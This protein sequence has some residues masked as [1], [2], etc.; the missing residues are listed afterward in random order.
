MHAPGGASATCVSKDISSGIVKSPSRF[1]FRE[2]WT[3][4]PRPLYCQ[5][6][7]EGGHMKNVLMVFTEY[8]FQWPFFGLII[9]S[10]C[11]A[12]GKPMTFWQFVFTWIG[13]A[14]ITAPII[15][16]IIQQMG[17]GG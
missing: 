10:I 4:R 9:L 3:L 1:I 17:R 13:L 16:Y 6:W 5:R 11:R 12:K 15:G 8:V 2:G 7:I 14:V